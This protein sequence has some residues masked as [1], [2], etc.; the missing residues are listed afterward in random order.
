[1]VGME[2]TVHEVLELRWGPEQNKEALQIGV[3]QTA[4]FS[5]DIDVSLFKSSDELNWA[6]P[7]R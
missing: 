6:L 7:N 4:I 3:I 5:S 1:M 2:D